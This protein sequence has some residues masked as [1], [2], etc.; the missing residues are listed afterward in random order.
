MEELRALLEAAI[1]ENV[2]NLTPDEAKEWCDHT[3]SQVDKDKVYTSIY[4]KNSK[5]HRNIERAI[6]QTHKSSHLVLVASHL[7]FFFLII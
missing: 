4:M 1:S 2:L 5:V 3:L 6:S 7:P